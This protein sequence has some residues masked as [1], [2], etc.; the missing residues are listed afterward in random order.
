MS[1]T[2]SWNTAALMRS[3]R[4][5]LQM[6][7]LTL[8]RDADSMTTSI[9]T[10]LMRVNGPSFI[11]SN[12]CQLAPLL[13]GSDIWALLKLGLSSTLSINGVNLLERCVLTDRFHVDLKRGSLTQVGET[14]WETG[15][16]TLLPALW[17]LLHRCF[18]VSRSRRTRYVVGP[19]PTLVPLKS[20]VVLPCTA[21]SESQCA[22]G[23][24]LSC[25]E[26]FAIGTRSNS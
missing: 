13:R 2:S 23:H 11:S 21:S 8:L 6:M 9:S 24:C 14:H 26:P 25:H 17:L 16:S 15:H 3:C 18:I 20:V 1:S 4:L 22:S 10:C 5:V 7:I 12:Q 19:L